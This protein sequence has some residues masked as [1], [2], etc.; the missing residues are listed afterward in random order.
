MF[1][2]H[3]S[4]QLLETCEEDSLSQSTPL[5]NPL[6]SLSQLSLNSQQ[7][8]HPTNGP[9]GALCPLGGGGGSH[10]AQLGGQPGAPH[11][12]CGGYTLLGS[13]GSGC[14]GLLLGQQASL[15]SQSG[16]TLLGSPPTPGPL[17]PSPSLSV[18]CQSQHPAALTENNSPMSANSDELN[19]LNAGVDM[20]AAGSPS[21]NPGSQYLVFFYSSNNSLTSL[22]LEASVS[23]PLLTRASSHTS[24]S[25]TNPKASGEDR[26]PRSRRSSWRR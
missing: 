19:D 23:R 4:E 13:H 15:G 9:L 11:A 5:H 1:S 25:A 18:N 16:A 10:L 2:P 20:L 6:N 12:P 24:A 26:A 8:L 21:S 14:N 17:L 7:A 22:E 3:G